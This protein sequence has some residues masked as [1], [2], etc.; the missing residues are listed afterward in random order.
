MTPCTS[1]AATECVETLS[2]DTRA[3]EFVEEAY[4]HC[5]AI[6]ATGE[7]VAF[8]KSTRVATGITQQDPAVVVGDGGAKK[9][10][11]AFVAAISQHRN[12]NREPKTLPNG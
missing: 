7:A 6:A 12:W 2:T 5:K 9:V 8:L 4:K 10:A 1:R 3:V 11:A